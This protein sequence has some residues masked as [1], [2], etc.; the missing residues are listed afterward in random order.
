MRRPGPLHRLFRYGARCAPVGFGLWL[1]WP[2]GAFTEWHRARERF[3]NRQAAA[4]RGVRLV[5]RRAHGAHD[6][7]LDHHI[8]RPA[9]HQQM[10]DIVAPDDDELPASIHRGRIDHG[11]PGLP[12]A[13][14]G[15]AEALCGVAAQSPGDEADEPEYDKEAKE[16][17]QA[18]RDLYAKQDIEHGLLVFLHA[19]QV[20]RNRPGLVNA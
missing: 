4:D 13:R 11:K 19:D 12:P 2:H 7:L 16:D 1:Q 15:S 6:I 18:D 3:G 14:R 10:L 5:T 17:L 8:G 9:D 20:R